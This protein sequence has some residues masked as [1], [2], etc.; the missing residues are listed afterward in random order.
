MESLLETLNFADLIKWLRSALMQKVALKKAT[1]DEPAYLAVLREINESSPQL[2]AS[3]QRATIVL[4]RELIQSAELQVEYCQQLL[5]L[6]AEVKNE[7]IVNLLKSYALSFSAENAID[8]II[9]Q[10]VLAALADGAPRLTINFWRTIAQQDPFNHAGMA[11]TA[12]A[13]LDI[14]EAI[15]ILPLLNGDVLSGQ[16]AALNLDLAWDR[17]DKRIK[18]IVAINLRKIL[19]NC[20]AAIT[21]PI[22]EWLSSASPETRSDLMRRELELALQGYLGNDAAPRVRSTKLCQSFAEAA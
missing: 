16:V 11:F 20:N 19:P 7:E 8:P 1:S 10:S 3:T 2:Q 5:F 13:R 9:R 12:A 4:L 22:R 17:I 6:S 14:I 15:K 21:L 18:P